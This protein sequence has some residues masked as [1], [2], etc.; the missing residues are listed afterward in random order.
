MSLDRVPIKQLGELEQNVDRLLATMR[1]TRTHRVPLYQALLQF[2]RELGEARRQR[3][4]DKADD[5]AR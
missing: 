4:D 3:F 2:E 1:K 5:P